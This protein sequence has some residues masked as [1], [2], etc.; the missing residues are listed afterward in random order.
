MPCSSHSSQASQPI[1]ALRFSYQGREGKE[2]CVHAECMAQVLI[3]DRGLVGDAPSF[4]LSEEADALVL[5][6]E[7]QLVPFCENLDATLIASRS[8]QVACF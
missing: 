3:Q 1:L 8:L 7:A 6:L 2:T 4:K 5:Q